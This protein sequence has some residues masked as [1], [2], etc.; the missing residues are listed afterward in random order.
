MYPTT[1][2]QVLLQKH[3]DCCRFI[4][5]HFLQT[6]IEHYKTTKKTITWIDL[7]NRIPKLKQEKPW[8]AEIGSQSLQQSA[9][10]LDNAYTA[11]FRSNAG[12]PKFKT[13]HK[14]RKSFVVV[15]TNG[16]IKVDTACNKLTLPK[17]TN[18]KGR[19]DNRIR[20]IFHREI[21]GVIKQA[22]VTQDK[23]GRYY[24]SILSESNKDLPTKPTP[25][26]NK[27]IGIDFGIKTFL[28]LSNGTKIDNPAY[29]KRSQNKLTKHQQDLAKLD[30]TTTIYKSKREQ[31]TKLYAKIA[32]QRKDFLDKL[33]H[34]LTN[35]SQ[36][37]TICVEDLSMT[38]MKDSNYSPANK[39]IGDYAWNT[40][41]RML[42]YKSDWNG[43]NFLKIGKFEPSSKTCN[44][45]G[46]VNHKLTLTDR[47][48]KCDK[49]SETHDRD[50]NAAK[51][52]LDFSFPKTYFVQDRNYP[53]EA[54]SL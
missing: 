27:A 16:N 28:T 37:G 48:W 22:T 39:V 23:D 25:N 45:C 44:V 34:K 33:S 14:S 49:C 3:F 46:F 38:E 32:R 47:E 18:R 19:K 7:A 24:V 26:R 17:F 21:D 20:C 1:E 9:R 50:V 35:D 11:F 53:I 12:F 13:K 31:I 2:Q 41:V 6:K 8:L 5:N 54:S 36:I 43:K 51:N 30:K 52:I 29:L 4:Y 40:F 10:H 42:Q 15:M